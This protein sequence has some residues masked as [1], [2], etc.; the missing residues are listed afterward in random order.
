MAKRKTLGENMAVAT[1]APS[2]SRNY[3]D[4]YTKIDSLQGKEK[5]QFTKGLTLEEKKGYIK[6]L[7]E[8]NTQ[9]VSGIWRCF[10]PVGGSLEMSGKA[11]EGEDPTKYVFVDG[12]EYT[13]PRY[14]AKRFESDFQGIG[15][16]YPTHSHV[17]DNEGKPTVSVG[18]K[19]RRFGFSSMEFQ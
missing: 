11:Y 4:L 2:T 6:Y 18:K 1:E 17:L 12:V 19:N 7:E 13:V 16:W 3:N 10:E 14:I 9:M 15:T 8:R 5:L